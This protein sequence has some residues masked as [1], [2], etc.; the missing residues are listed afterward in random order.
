MPGIDAQGDH[1]EQGR[2]LR[3]E[4]ERIN[5]DVRIIDESPL[6]NYSLKPEVK[7]EPVSPVVVDINA[8]LTYEDLVPA[9]AVIGMIEIISELPP[10]PDTYGP[11][12]SIVEMSTA[13]QERLL[14]SSLTS[15][16]W[17]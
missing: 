15:T 10:L 17:L 1:C 9:Q 14:S 4:E 16:S 8:P 6:V 13:D 7:L 11:D 12:Y 5:V 2:A 3:E